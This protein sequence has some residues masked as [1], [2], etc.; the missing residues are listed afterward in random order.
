MSVGVC[1]QDFRGCVQDLGAA[2]DRPPPRPP[3]TG[4]PFLRTPPPPDRTK[5]RTFSLIRHNFQFF[6]PLLGVL[7]LNFA[8]VLEAGTLPGLH[9]T[10]R[11]PKRAHFRPR[12]F[13]TPPKFHE[14]AGEGKKARNFGPPTLLSPTLRGPTLRGPHPVGPPPFGASTLRGLPPFGAPTLRGPHPSGPHPPPWPKAALA[15][16]SLA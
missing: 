3:S 4:P 11:E 2:P 15:F 9:T 14:R 13:K 5:F 16:T 10:A 12:R 7:S 6:L 1:V 8:G